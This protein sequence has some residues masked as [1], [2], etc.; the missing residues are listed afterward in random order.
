MAGAP[1]VYLC[2]AFSLCFNF[3][4]VAEEPFSLT[5]ENPLIRQTAPDQPALITIKG[6]TNLPNRTIINVVLYYLPHVPGTEP[7]RQK[8]IDLKKCPVTDGLYQVEFGPFTGQLPSGIYIAAIN[9]DPTKQYKEV[10]EKIGSSAEPL[11][12]ETRCALG[13]LDDLNQ[14]RTGLQEQIRQKSLKLLNLYYSLKENIR[15]EITRPAPDQKGRREWIKKILQSV[16]ATAAECASLDPLGIFRLVS[17]AKSFMESFDDHLKE[18]V[19]LSEQVLATPERNSS[20]NY[21]ILLKAM[22]EFQRRTEEGLA[23][24]GVSKPVDPAQVS[25]QIDRIEKQL[26]ALQKK[27]TAPPEE[28]NSHEYQIWLAREKETLTDLFLTLSAYLESD[29][30]QTITALSN[31][32][33]KLW[34]IMES[35]ETGPEKLNRFVKERAPIDKTLKQIKADSLSKNNSR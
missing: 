7:A 12:R 23:Q 26:N 28:V 33:V 9:F 13:T 15:Q 24:L 16:E 10:K 4:A 18:L 29:D 14:E 17:Q 5:A 11:N 3:L 19:N 6:Q 31:N 2:L 8:L 1:G 30:Y 22:D 21:E 32:L 25:G 27:T 20:Q 35:T 34:P